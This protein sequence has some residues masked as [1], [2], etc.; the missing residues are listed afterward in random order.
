MGQEFPRSKDDVTVRCD[1][2]ARDLGPAAPALALC[3][4]NGD[5][6]YFMALERLNVRRQ[7]PEQTGEQHTRQV[8]NL[9]RPPSRVYGYVQ[10]PRTRGADFICRRCG[11]RPRISRQA[12]CELAEQAVA[13]RRHDAYI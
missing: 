10:R 3:S 13:A 7:T 6:W 5:G 8:S 1:P 9:N 4:R 2:C 11:H 12:L